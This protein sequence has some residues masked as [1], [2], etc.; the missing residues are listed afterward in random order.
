MEEIVFRGLDRVQEYLKLFSI[1]H[2]KEIGVRGL[3]RPGISEALY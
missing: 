1:R 3:G 2:M